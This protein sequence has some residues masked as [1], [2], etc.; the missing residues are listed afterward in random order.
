MNKQ[1]KDLFDQMKDRS[2]DIANMIIWFDNVYAN[3]EDIDNESIKMIEELCD[4]LHSTYNDTEV[5][6]DHFHSI[7]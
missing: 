4:K 6:H 7:Y 3:I 2:Q 5:L 1:T